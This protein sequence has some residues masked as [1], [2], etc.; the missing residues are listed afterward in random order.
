MCALPLK[1]H[2]LPV[3]PNHVDRPCLL[4]LLRREDG[5]LPLLLERERQTRRDE[6]AIDMEDRSTKK[7]TPPVPSESGD[8]RDLRRT[9]ANS[10]GGTAPNGQ[11]QTSPTAPGS[12][13]GAAPMVE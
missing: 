2:R 11:P 1:L 13:R 7:G 8:I 9:G 4:L 10:N 3:R 6:V 12:R 5:N